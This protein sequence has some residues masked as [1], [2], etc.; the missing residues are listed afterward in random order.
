MFG[1]LFFHLTEVNS[2]PPFPDRSRIR[3]VVGPTLKCG[4]AFLGFLKFFLEF[5]KFSQPHIVQNQK[6]GFYS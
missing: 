4:N 6:W 2:W 5:I 3:K 1:L